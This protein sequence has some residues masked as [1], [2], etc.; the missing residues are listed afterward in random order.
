MNLGDYFNTAFRSIFRNKKSNS[1]IIVTVI[2]SILV[3]ASLTFYTNI[4]DY[5]DAEITK[6]VASRSILVPPNLNLEDKGMDELSKIKHVEAVYNSKYSMVSSIGSTFKNQYVDGAVGLVYGSLK[7]QPRVIAGR[8]FE[9]SDKGVAICPIDFYPDIS[10]YNLNVSRNGLLNGNDLIGKT[11]TINY[12]NE[13]SK[14]KLDETFKIIG[15][16]DNKSVM[17]F[18]NE[19][20]VL[21]EDIIRIVEFVNP[22]KEDVDYATMVIVDSMD[23][24]DYVKKQ[25]MDIPNFLDENYQLK[26]ASQIDT[27][28][29]NLLSVSCLVVILIILLVSIALTIA[30]TRKK[31]LNEIKIIGVLRNFGYGKKTISKM[32]FSEIILTNLFSYIIGLIIFLVLLLVLTNYIFAGLLY[33]IIDINLSVFPIILALIIS[34]LPSVVV[35]FYINEKCG[36]NIADLIGNE[37]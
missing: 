1:Y 18:N 27:G 23:N 7:I 34:I 5:V 8:G 9:E 17:K 32:Y 12:I 15:V 16:Y 22:T 28:L 36:V 20:Y 37:E 11:F 33:S 10:A 29:V 19:C 26:L 3:M 30:Y 13:E 21:S 14:E 24:L 2:C 4:V 25:I 31:L 35:I 6:N